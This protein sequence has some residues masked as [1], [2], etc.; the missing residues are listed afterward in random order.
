MVCKIRLKDVV[1]EVLMQPREWFGF[2]DTASGEIVWVSLEELRA[3]EEGL[4]IEQAGLSDLDYELVEQILEDEEGRFVRLPTPEEVDEYSIMKDFCLSLEDQK[5][6]ETLL[7]AIRG[8]GAFRRFKD[9]VI[10]YGLD[11]GWYRFR[12]WAVGEIVKEWC[13]EH[14]IEVIGE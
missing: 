8:R 2:L 12:D 5:L 1:S 13:E 4:P 14:N 10:R 6:R 11:D 7:S 3:A 9:A